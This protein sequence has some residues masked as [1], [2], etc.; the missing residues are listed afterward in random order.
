MSQA[1]FGRLALLLSPAFL[2]FDLWDFQGGAR[3]ELAIFAVC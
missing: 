2:A 1:N 3:K